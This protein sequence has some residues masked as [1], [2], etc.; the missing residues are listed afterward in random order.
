[1]SLLLALLVAAQT[2]DPWVRVHE[3]HNCRLAR[4]E[5]VSFADLHRDRARLNGRCVALRG[6]WSGR[7][8]FRD[9]A[10]SRVPRAEYAEATRGDRIGLYGSIAVERGASRP[11]AYVAVGL[12]MDCRSLWEGQDF[13]PGYCHNNMDGP[14]LAVTAL[15]RR[16]WPTLRGIW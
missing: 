8:L 10:A 5:R 9:E 1:M 3:P 6:I 2:R 15:Y 16:R 13:V 12:L 7:A 11:D 4:A 14:F